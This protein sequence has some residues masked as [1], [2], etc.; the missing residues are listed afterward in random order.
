MS[1][2]KE[3]GATHKP[4]SQQPTNELRYSSYPYEYIVYIVIYIYIDFHFMLTH[5]IHISR[6]HFYHTNTLIC[7]LI[8]CKNPYL[9]KYLKQK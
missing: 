5:S 4:Q 8:I 9:Y 3:G 6:G 7:M 1:T 2:E